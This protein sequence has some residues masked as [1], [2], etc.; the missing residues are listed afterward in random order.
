MSFLIDELKRL[1]A[2]KDLNILGTPAEPHF[3]AVCRTAQSLFHT[4]IAVI[5][6]VEEDRQWFKAKC[7]LNIEGT[8]RDIAFCNFTILSDK[9]LIVEDTTKDARFATN[10]LVTGEHNIR[11]YA[12]APLILRSGIRL[13]SLSIMDNFPR[14]FS[15]LQA[16]QLQ[17]L[18]E[19]V[20][21][22]LHLYETKSAE[23]RVNA[24]LFTTGNALTESQARYRLLANTL[25][26]MVWVMSHDD[27]TASYMNA[28]FLAYYGEIG[29]ARDERTSRNHPEDAASMQHAWEEALLNHQAYEIEGR[30]LRHDGVYRW[31]R[32][33]MTPVRRHGKIV[34][35]LG[36][37][38]DLND[39]FS[40]RERLEETT[41]LL[42]LAQE[43][44]GAGIW[45]WDLEKRVVRHSLE[46]ARMHN[47]AF[48][49]GA[50]E[51]EVGVEDWIARVHPDDFERTRA[52]HLDVV[53][54]GITYKIEFRILLPNTT[55]GYRWLLGF[56]R[57]IRDEATGKPLRIIGFNVDI[58]ERRE[59]QEALLASEAQ[60][61]VS[62][63][64]LAFALESGSDGLWDLDISTG[65]LWLSDHLQTTLGYQ[66]GEIEP[67]L[68]SWQ[69]LIHP[70]DRPYVRR[71]LAD[72]FEQRTEG[73]DHEHR[74]RK[75]GGDYAW[76]LARGKV[77]DRDTRGT[78]LRM[79]GTHI[80]IT[81]RKLAEQRLVHMARHDPL[82]DLGNRT[83]FHE[84]LKEKLGQVRLG[85]G[86]V[87]LFCLDLDRFK[88]INDMLGHLAGDTLLCEVAKRL[89]ATLQEGDTVARLG[90]DEFAVI[91]G[92][93]DYVHQAGRRARSLIQ[94]IEQPYEIDGRVI[95]IGVTIGIALAPTDGCDPDDLFKSADVAL[96][97]AKDSQPGTY[98]FYEASMDAAIARRN[99]LE[100][101]LREA[102]KQEEIT[103]HYQ[104]VMK[105]NG[106]S[107][108]GFEALLRWSH[109][110]DGMISPLEFIPI[111]EDTGLIV[112][113]GSWVLQEA[114]RFAASWPDHLKIAVNVSAA[115]FLK[116][117]LEASV[118]N[119]LSTSGLAPHRLELEIT[120]SVLIHEP[121]T[122]LACLHRL[123]NV[124]VRVA[125]DDFGTGYSSLSYLRTF[126]FDKIKIDKSFVQDIEN[127]NT[128]V[129]IS[130][131]VSIA[132]Q[133]NAT[134]T[135]EG[136]ET[137]LQRDLILDQSCD[138]V[139]GYFYSKPLNE[140]KASDFLAIYC[141]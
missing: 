38:L 57:V 64:R 51:I 4:S 107:I 126:P 6:L 33:I 19:I 13:G 108:C 79:V 10:P 56:G 104:P 3:D 54:T 44:A 94:A 15:N 85:R 53:R 67:S 52:N 100:F 127:P 69:D 31:H 103:L 29:R 24:A 62:E 97:R 106:D 73:Y 89:Q 96:C 81:D 123:R 130:A 93:L 115:Q 133:T 21:A 90:G 111:A 140:Q 80:D 27:M 134:V 139:Q 12:G 72:H 84:R 42:R 58:T 78:P 5:T 37:A 1:S 49:E 47:L 101:D 99:R 45:E 60:L 18:G 16:L 70:D 43:A 22:H 55:E 86:L 124:G 40:A 91:I 11:F 122:A 35:W 48:E 132:K 105:P 17:D 109:H 113:L 34:E 128:A 71:L 76:V 74:M 68:E 20:V 30:L 129:I 46:S 63:E 121:E 120:E 125:L 61:R 7:G 87:A 88:A 59:A 114:C 75:K 66:P 28:A 2:L 50:P 137:G 136:V 8:S 98:Q 110:T 117:G 9:V 26:Q 112:P 41:D 102:L 118:L 92:H 65:K 135:A 116:P 14:G 77:M 131:I 32:L 141:S 95:S 39:I 138:E 23:R 83:L 36:T 119:A 82:T 25:P